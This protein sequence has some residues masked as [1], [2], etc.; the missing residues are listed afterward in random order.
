MQW[1][2]VE[3]WYWMLW[4]H[5]SYFSAL[6]NQFLLD[7]VLE[8]FPLQYLCCW[9]NNQLSEKCIPAT[10]LLLSVRVHHCVIVWAFINPFSFQ[11]LFLDF[12]CLWEEDCCCNSREVGRAQ[13]PVNCSAWPR[14]DRISPQMFARLPPL[15]IIPSLQ[16]LTI[17]SFD[18]FHLLS[19]VCLMANIPLLAWPTQSPTLYLWECLNVQSMQHIIFCIPSLNLFLYSKSV[20]DKP[21]RIDSSMPWYHL[22][23]NPLH[24]SNKRLYPKLM[25]KHP[26]S[27]I[28]QNTPINCKNASKIPLYPYLDP[29]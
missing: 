2:L 13:D 9:M 23:F 4:S 1:I 10:A 3:S 19:T 28:P 15:C 24:S 6:I 18:A 14:V 26:C 17:Q 12:P 20:K 21:D 5:C 27:I 25:R 11:T 16:R 7:Q 22:S 29:N 8:H